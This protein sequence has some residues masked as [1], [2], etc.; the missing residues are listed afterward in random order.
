M[1]SDRAWLPSES[2]LEATVPC[3]RKPDTRKCWD[4]RKNRYIFR[5]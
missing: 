3:D 2:L 4:G 1:R 5:M